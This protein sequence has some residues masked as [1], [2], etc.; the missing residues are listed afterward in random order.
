MA[1]SHCAEPRTGQ[2]LG[3]NELYETGTG[4]EECTVHLN[5]DG[6]GYLLSAILLVLV[7]VHVTVPVPRGVNTP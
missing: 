5:K 2:V 3:T 4:I 7:P 1:Y 6:G